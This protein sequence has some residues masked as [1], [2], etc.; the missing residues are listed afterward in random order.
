[1]DKTHVSEL[2]KRYHDARKAGEYP[3]FD[4][5]EIDEMLEWLEVKDKYEDCKALVDLGLSQHPGNSLLLMRKCRYYMY[6]F[7]YEMA[8]ETLNSI[9]DAA[10]IDIEMMRLECYYELDDIDAILKRIE[11]LTESNCEYLEDILEYIVPMLNDKDMKDASAKLI[12]KGLS[13]FPKNT[14]LMDELGYLYELSGQYKKAISIS[15]KLLDSNPHSY[16]HWFNLGRLYA[17]N[18]NY[19]AAIEAFEFA[20]ACSGEDTKDTDLELEVL[21]AYCFFMNEN[22]EKALEKYS[23]VSVDSTPK[24]YVHIQT[25]MSECYAKLE[26]FENAYQT[27]RNILSDNAEDVRISMKFVRYAIA[28]NHRTEATDVLNFTIDILPDNLGNL[29]EEVLFLLKKEKIIQ[30]L[31]FVDEII[32]HIEDIDEDDYFLDDM[33]SL[34]L[35][36]PRTWDYNFIPKPTPAA[37]LIEAYLLKPMNKN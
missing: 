37:R 6:E 26:D 7:Q 14:L 11:A 25:M 13:H 33:T 12:R 9:P 24:L 22:Y 2:L 35:N 36:C 23:Q 1:M 17:F 29:A 34:L 28:S 4:T 19:P 21:L 31:V 3:Y 30:A 10:N 32:D 27:L 5:D 20:V 8:L 18:F 16:D 15:N